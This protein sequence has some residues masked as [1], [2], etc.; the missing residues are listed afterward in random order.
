MISEQDMDAINYGDELDHDLI[1]T[2][3]LEDI[4]DGSQT[5]TN[6]NIREARY[7]IRDRIR[8]RQPE[9]KGALK[10]TQNMGKVLHKVFTTVVKEI[11]QALPPLG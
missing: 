1:S 2:D 5:H 9:W 3:M 6:V 10:A 7:K 11:S 8:K 4:C